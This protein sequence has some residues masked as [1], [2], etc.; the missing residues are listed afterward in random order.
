MFEIVTAI[1]IDARP[2]IVWEHIVDL[3][4]WSEWHPY[5][6]FDSGQVKLGSTLRTVTVTPEQEYRLDTT[7]TT[8]GPGYQFCW[9]GEIQEPMYAKGI[10][11]FSVEAG[12]T[13]GAVL[14]QTETVT[15]PLTE[16]KDAPAMQARGQAG[17]D[18]AN[19]AFKAYLEGLP[20]GTE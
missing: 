1:A 6:H 9:T 18:A 11:C 10:H 2:E 8:V 13:G 20:K 7:V 19:A 5:M 15:G 3:K 17:F 16:T 4:E 12:D 14:H